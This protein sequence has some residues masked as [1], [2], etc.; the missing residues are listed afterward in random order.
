M[1]YC[2]PNEVR[3]LAVQMTT[4]S[5][6]PSAT[7]DLIRNLIERVSRLF[8]LEVG[9]DPGYFDPALYPVWESNHTYVVGDTVIPTTPN[10]HKY[11][12]TTAG[13]SG[14]SEPSWTTGAGATFVSG[15]ATFTENGADV[16][17][18]ARTFYGDGTNFLR[19]DPYVPGS[20]NTTLALPDGYT[21]PSFIQKDGF[22]VRTSTDGILSTRPRFFNNYGYGQW[23]IGVPIIATAK[24]GYA[25]TPAD[26]K[27]AIIEWVINVWRETD[28][29]SL[30]LVN[31][32]G[33]PLRESVP[34][35]VKEVIKLYR[36]KTA[37]AVFV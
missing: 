18:T 33:M 36:L 23:P 14:S 20:L 8:D 9:C 2:S 32:D 21:A 17:A 15:A 25:T 4:S 5:V 28:P 11:R 12:V 24:W 6:S 7:D 27:L 16:A 13:V 31:I 10:A 26:V 22:L 19:L 35:R 3:A 1:S 34:P 30:K 37:R 29:T